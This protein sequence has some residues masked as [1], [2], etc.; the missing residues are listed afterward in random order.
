MKKYSLSLI[1]VFVMM[2][3]S[4]AAVSAQ[5]DEESQDEAESTPVVACVGAPAPRLSVGDMGEVAQTYSSIR[6]GV[7]SPIVLR[8]MY[9]ANGDQFEVLSEPSCNGPHYW[10]E[11]DFNGLTGWVTNGQGATYW[12]Q[13]VSAEMAD[14]DMAS[15]DEAT[16]E[17]TDTTDETATDDITQSGDS[18]STDDTADSDDMDDTD[19]A[20]DE[21]MTDESGG[22]TTP[23]AVEVCTGAPL[24]RLAI[25]ATG[26]VAQTYSTLR[27]SIGSSVVLDV[28]YSADGDEFEVV[29]GP[30]CAGPHYWY[31]VTHDGQTGWVTEGTGATYWLVPTSN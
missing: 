20:S 11:V 25:G 31:Q 14:T 23:V 30:V 1:L 26:T 17:E 8:V 22:L 29:D 9:S 15:D 27:D 7:G 10:Y 6:A 5:D 28:M 18:D 16:T 4:L 2:A 3:L 21:D 19:T 24:A 13:P 12:I